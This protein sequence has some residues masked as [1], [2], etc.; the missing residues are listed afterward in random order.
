MS[1][2]GQLLVR[3]AVGSRRHSGRKKFPVDEFPVDT[4][5]SM[6]LLILG[7][8]ADPPKCWKNNLRRPKRGLNE[9]PVKSLAARRW[10]RSQGRLRVEQVLS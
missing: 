7:S 8:A 4:R 9:L 1:R 2:F 3:P 10:D 6:N 5:P